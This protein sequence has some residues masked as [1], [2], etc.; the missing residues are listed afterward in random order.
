[1]HEYPEDR[2]MNIGELDEQTFLDKLQ[3]E[4]DRAKQALIEHI[5]LYRGEI[6]RASAGVTASI[7]LAWTDKGGVDIVTE[8][9]VETP[10]APPRRTPAQFKTDTLTGE[11]NLFTMAPAPCAPPR[12]DEQGLLLGGDLVSAAA[13]PE[14]L[15]C[16]AIA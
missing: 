15:P 3:M 2:P 8:T 11:V 5:A 10:S 16:A 12:D 14:G 1:M 6:A 4:F 13:C 7:T 9:K